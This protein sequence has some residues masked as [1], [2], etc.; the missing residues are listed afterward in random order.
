MNGVVMLA[1]A[2]IL[3]ANQIRKGSEQQRGL[4][5][6]GLLLIVPMVFVS[7]FAGLG[8]PPTEPERWWATAADQEIRYTLLVLAGLFVAG[9]FAVLRECL[10]QAGEQIYSTLGFTGILISTTLYVFYIAGGTTLTVEALRIWAASG[11]M[12]EWI[13]P[14]DRVI[15]IVGLVEVALT[16]LATAAFIAALDVLGGS[17]KSAAECLWPYAWQQ[18][19]WLLFLRSSPEQPKLAFPFSFWPFPQCHS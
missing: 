5:L 17:G 6:A 2:W 18:F 19:P 16:Y 13:R 7:M 12:P 10:R 1:A 4:T 3:G 11:K 9:G 14:L 15:A 8:P